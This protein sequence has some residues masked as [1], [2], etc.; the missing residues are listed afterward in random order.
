MLNLVNKW[1]KNIDQGEIV[2]AIFF[3]IEKAF[4]VVNHAIMLQKL[5]LYKFDQTVLNWVSSYLT[6]R[7]QCIV[8]NNSMSHMQPIKAGV[9][10]GSVLGPVLFLLFI[11]DLL[12]LLMRQILKCPTMTLQLILQIKIKR[13]WKPIFKMEQHKTCIDAA[14]MTCTFTYEKHHQ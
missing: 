6:N 10:Q 1:L 12:C 14:K 7:K 9:S 2:G 3:E 5:E 8:Q 4:D 11:N 13:K